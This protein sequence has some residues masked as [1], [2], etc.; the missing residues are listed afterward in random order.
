M[1]QVL[2]CKLSRLVEIYWWYKVSLSGDILPV[3][4]VSVSSEMLAVANLM[5]LTPTCSHALQH[6]I[7][8]VHVA[9]EVIIS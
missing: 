7:A 8:A 9:G 4:V 2:L 3:L 6:R 5:L 1:F